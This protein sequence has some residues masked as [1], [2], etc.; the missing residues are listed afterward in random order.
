MINTKPME[1]PFHLRERSTEGA[2]LSC[3]F[4]VWILSIY[5]RIPARARVGFIS[6]GVWVA[7]CLRVWPGQAVPSLYMFSLVDYSAHMF[8]ARA[9]VVILW[10]ISV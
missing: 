3:W 1:V 7:A 6:V 8:A 4:A 10:A 2:L 5:V 9:R